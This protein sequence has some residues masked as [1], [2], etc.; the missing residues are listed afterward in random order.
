M[1]NY[2]RLTRKFVKGNYSYTPANMHKL[3]TYTHAP[4][5]A[6]AIFSPGSISYPKWSCRE[7]KIA[8]ALTELNFPLVFHQQLMKKTTKAQPAEIN[9]IRSNAEWEKSTQLLLWPL[10]ILHD[11][12]ATSPPPP[13]LLSVAERFEQ[14][15]VWVEV[16]WHA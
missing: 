2:L 8:S 5:S 3:Y 1:S 14:A 7:K 12:A 4:A 10:N 15:L 16:R 13:T 9:L 11:T 6:L